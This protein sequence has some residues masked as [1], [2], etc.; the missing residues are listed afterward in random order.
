MSHTRNISR[1]CRLLRSQL[2][3]DDRLASW[4]TLSYIRREVA[5]LEEMMTREYPRDWREGLHE[6]VDRAL[7]DPDTVIAFQRREETS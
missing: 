6:Q 4:Q 7:D 5:S 2:G 1:A 3:E